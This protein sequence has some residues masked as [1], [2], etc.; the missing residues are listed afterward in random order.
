MVSLES[1]AREEGSVSFTD[2]MSDVPRKLPDKGGNGIE[3]REGIYKV[4]ATDDCIV[5][6]CTNL[7]LYMM[8]W[9]LNVKEMPIKGLV[10]T[11]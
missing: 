8:D 2:N 6:C 9:R 11:K 10:G 5:L 4:I 7:A 1:A 3:L